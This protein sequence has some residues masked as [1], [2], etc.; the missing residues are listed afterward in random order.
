MTVLTGQVDDQDILQDER[1]VDMDDVISYLDPETSQFT[2]M[3]MQIA[4]KDAFSSKV[5]WLEDELFP[6]LSSLAASATSAETALTV[7][8]GEG[9]FFR[10]GDVVRIATTGEAIHIDSVASD[11]LS[12]DRSVG[13][14]A[15]ASATSGVQLVII[16]NAS[17]QGATL[18]TRKVLQRVAQ[19]NYTQIQRNPYGFTNTLTASE[20]YGG[21]EP[22][23]ER[24]KK[25]I[26]HKRA[27][28][29]TLFWG[30]RDLDTSGS[31]PIGYCGGAYEFI[32]SNVQDAGGTLTDANFDS[33]MRDML[34]H[35]SQNKVLF[36]AP[37]VAQAMSGFLRDAWQPTSV[38]ERLWGAKVDA[39]ISG[40]YGFRIP[41]VVKRDWNDFSTSSDQFG[42][43]AFLIDMEYVK[44]RPLRTRNTKLLRNRQANDADSY[45]EEYL[46]EFSLQFKQEE[47]H[48]LI[49][50]V[51]G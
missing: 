42:G 5:E 6:R 39:F 29:Y 8:T 23:K 37:V 10:A 18:G 43:W 49:V 34:Q 21:D 9:D 25:L 22:D 15:A 47:V 20:L 35:G 31:T 7:A 36:V 30:A 17:A 44:Y 13:S 12:V 3:L 24:E 27:L 48:G 38:G 28:E 45:D 33:Y 1:V 41:V 19:Y 46:T 2:T 51:T 32:S 40:A 14:V 16:G 50:G 26:E 4:S 11:V